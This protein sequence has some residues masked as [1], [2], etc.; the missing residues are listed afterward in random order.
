MQVQADA[1]GA[2]A[3]HVG[4]VV[5]AGDFVGV[6]HIAVRARAALEERR[7]RR[8]AL[9]IN[10]HAAVLHQRKCQDTLSSQHRDWA[11]AFEAG[12]VAPAA[13]LFSGA[14]GIAVG[15]RLLDARTELGERHVLRRHEEVAHFLELLDD[16]CIARGG[17]VLAQHDG[18]GHVAPVDQAIGVD[19]FG[20]ARVIARVAFDRREVL[21]FT[22][23]EER[24]R[25]EGVDHWVAERTVIVLSGEQVLEQLSEDAL[26]LL[27]LGRKARRE[28]AVARA[29][30]QRRRARLAGAFEHD[31]DATY[32]GLGL[33]CFKR[34]GEVEQRTLR[35]KDLHAIAVP[36]RRGEALARDADNV[37]T[38][39]DASRGSRVG[40]HMAHHEVRRRLGH[41]LDAQTGAPEVVVPAR[42][43]GI[44]AVAGALAPRLTVRVVVDLSHER[45]RCC[46]EDEGA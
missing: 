36:V 26:A 33:A 15:V 29:D 38:N 45:R 21:A 22:A 24:E 3:A 44:G 41:E 42:H 16:P 7:R 4:P 5:V 20:R 10:R 37:I 39:L 17:V 9:A 23:G 18:R 2:C 32:A 28:L 6:P 1:R 35:A 40:E 27:A 46:D 31:F 30:G 11:V 43:L 12:V 8:E 34:D 14:G 13:V 19:C 25:R